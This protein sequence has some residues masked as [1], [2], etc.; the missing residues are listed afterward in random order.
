[1]CGGCGKRFERKAALNAH[2]QIC[3]K[4]K[5]ICDISKSKTVKTIQEKPKNHTV[6][7]TIPGKS[8]SPL[9]E[10]CKNVI[11]DDISNPNNHISNSP[12]TTLNEIESNNL[13]NKQEEILNSIEEI[14]G[15]PLNSKVNIRKM[16]VSSDDRDDPNEDKAESTQDVPCHENEENANTDLHEK[17]LA[18]KNIDEQKAVETLKN[19]PPPHIVNVNNASTKSVNVQI[20]LNILEN[21]HVRTISKSSIAEIIG[22]PSTSEEDAMIYFNDDQDFD[23][24]TIDYGDL[25]EANFVEN[26]NFTDNANQLNSNCF[27]TQSKT[28]EH[29]DDNVKNELDHS[30]ASNIE[31][32]SSVQNHENEPNEF[33]NEYHGIYSCMKMEEETN[34]EDV[35]IYDEIKVEEN[36]IIDENKYDISD[37]CWNSD[38]FEH[39][40]EN[41][42]TECNLGENFHIK[43]EPFLSE[44]NLKDNYPQKNVDE[45]SS[46]NTDLQKSAL[47]LKAAPFMDEEKLTC[48]S[49]LLNFKNLNNLHLHMSKHFKLYKFQ[50][51]KCNFM[52]VNKESGV[53]HA[54]TEHKTGEDIILH[55]PKWRRSHI[56]VFNANIDFDGNNKV[57]E[58]K[59]TNSNISESKTT[60][61]NKYDVDLRKLI[62]NIILGPEDSAKMDINSIQNSQLNRP[63]RVRNK[64][65]KADFIYDPVIKKKK[66]M[67]D[68]NKDTTNSTTDKYGNGKFFSKKKKYKSENALNSLLK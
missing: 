14:I 15:L 2:F 30:Y 33:Q 19:K 6:K 38:N 56:S 7:K 25:E 40:N 64:C 17:E 60:N 36:V 16:S 29:I 9:N 44:S 57:C 20:P 49:C 23:I 59:I 54:K 34:D 51:I 27:D 28:N 26:N 67:V 41:T 46:S 32:K 4:R 45:N 31:E 3:T 5:A 65:L 62:F 18:P 61:E 66:N 63:T 8:N 68:A 24:I 11:E 37:I 52:S 21:S 35:V 47:I 39:R 58:T 10:K 42:G 22:L 48:L 1:M 43:N 53:H 12:K 50:C 13:P 55:I